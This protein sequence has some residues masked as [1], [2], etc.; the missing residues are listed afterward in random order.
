MRNVAPLMNSRATATV[1]NSEA[2]WPGPMAA[3]SSVNLPLPI[4]RFFYVRY[5]QPF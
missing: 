3:P 1:K 5:N 2:A 4:E